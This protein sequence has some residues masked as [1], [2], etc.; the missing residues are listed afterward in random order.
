MIMFDLVLKAQGKEP[1]K[2]DAPIFTMI[3]L[4]AKSKIGKT[5]DTVPLCARQIEIIKHIRNKGS[6]G[7]AA[8]SAL[9]GI[10]VAQVSVHFLKL[11]AKGIVSRKRELGAPGLKYIYSLINNGAKA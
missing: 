4:L 2:I 10:P 3:D 5:I 1:A 9:I 6:M 8:I 7:A 11:A